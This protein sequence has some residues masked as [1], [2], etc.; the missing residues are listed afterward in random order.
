MNNE[1]S[2]INKTRSKVDLKFIEKVVDKFFRISKIRK[3][4]SIVLVG[5]KRIRDINR[6][7]RKKDKVTDVLSFEESEAGDFF[8]EII[9][10]YAQIK[11]QAKKYSRNT[12]EEL[13][14][15]LI[16]GL[17]HLSG[18]EDH[19]EKGRKRMEELGDAIFNEIIKKI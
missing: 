16:H 4:V 2:I 7:Y 10:D 12:K 18:F 3:D 15:M 1:I 9:I 5:D 8:G 19:T 13:G 14:Y 17:L 11:R 6:E